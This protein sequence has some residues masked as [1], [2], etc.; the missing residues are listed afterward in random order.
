M[1]FEFEWINEHPTKEVSIELQ[2]QLARCISALSDKFE[3]NT[4]EF[5]IMIVDEQRI[6]EMNLE[7]RGKDQPT[8]VISFAL[9][10]N[11]EETGEDEQLAYYLGDVVI[12]LDIAEKQAHEYGHSLHRELCFLAVHGLL[13]LLGYD[14]ETEVEEKEMFDLQEEVLQEQGL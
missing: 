11:I 14:H 7:Y 8:D 9:N 4:G 3:D 12:C 6:H 1:A 13:H 10:D 2:D 5:S